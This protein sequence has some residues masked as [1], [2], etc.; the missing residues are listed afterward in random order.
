MRRIML[1]GLFVMAM[2]AAMACLWAGTVDV[3][4]ERWSAVDALARGRAGDAVVQLAAAALLLIVAVVCLVRST[5]TRV[6]RRERPTGT[7]S[8]VPT[9]VRR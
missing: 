3:G 7:M 4:T 8:P 5:R 9:Q 1:G 2:A 6:R